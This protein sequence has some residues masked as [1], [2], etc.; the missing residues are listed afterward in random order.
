MGSRSPPPTSSPAL[1]APMTSDLAPQ[2]IEADA[3]V[4]VSR[5]DRP[6]GASIYVVTVTSPTQGKGVSV[7]ESL[8]E[9]LAEV[10]AKLRV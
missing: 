2:T 10:E 4:L 8:V 9:A 3:Q 7:Y 1:N 5:I 6:N